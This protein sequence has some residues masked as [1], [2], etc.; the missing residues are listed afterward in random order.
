MKK[1]ILLI[2]VGTP[3][4]SDVKSVK[5]YLREFLSDPRMI[6]LPAIVRWILV[7][8]FIVPFRSRRSAAAYQKVWTKHGSPLWVNTVKFRN[9][10][11]K[12]LDGKYQVAVGMRYGS[13]SIAK[14][15]SELKDCTS[16]SVVPLFPQYSSS[17]T[18]SAIQ[19]TL[20]IL[21]KQWNIPA[22]N[23]INEF[24]DHPGFISSYAEVVRGALADKQVDMLLFSYHGLPERHIDK[25]DCTAACDHVNACPALSKSNAYC[26]RAQCYRTA[27]LIA[28]E[29]NLSPV[30]YRVAFQSRL[31]R[32]PWIKPYTDLLLP[33]LIKSD[34]KKIAVV[35]PSFVVDCLET[36]EEV[37]IR[38]REQW[39]ELGGE[40]FV[41][42]PCLNANPT[43]VK[44]IANKIT[45]G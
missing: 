37:N 20:E 25:S 30:L 41:F 34:V 10:L 2:N 42:V 18:G 7:N 36:L 4:S 38:L 29:L 23:I 9:E 8:I 32:T 31:G 5:R 24:Y 14:A 39:L 26:Y 15:L 35:C 16:L 44:A 33:E 3:N 27:D 1:G 45:A 43:W 28:K 21:H 13:P 40:E 12:E 17:A 22:I 11:V 6:D 19:K